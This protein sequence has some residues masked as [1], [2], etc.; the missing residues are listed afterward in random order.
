MKEYRF[1]FLYW[2]DEI[3]RDVNFLVFSK[4]KFATVLRHKKKYK[5]G[6]I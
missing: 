5:Y 2:H 6:Y 1:F 3:A 4:S